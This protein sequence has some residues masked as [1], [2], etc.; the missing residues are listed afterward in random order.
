MKIPTM[1]QAKAFIEE[2]EKFNPGKWIDHSIHVAEAAQR[3]AGEH[4]DLDQETAYILGLLHDIG[5]RKGVMQMRHSVE[6][7][8]FLIE[9]GFEDAARIC[10]THS[11]PYKDIHAI[12]GKWDCTDEDITLI[13]SY[14]DATEYDGYD[15]LVQLCDVLALP[16]G[17]CLMEK[18]FVDV[19]L[20]Y[21]TSNYTILKWKAFFE[22]K[23][24]LEAQIGRSVYSVLPGI[25]EN[26]FE[27]SLNEFSDEKKL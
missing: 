19:A 15:K 5:R 27:L 8:K 22:I 16:T 20:R 25:I 13:Q 9:L 3:I 1:Q 26:T 12:C 4:P 11:F 10:L 7:Y 6:G 24:E 21:G 17:F 2:A 18:R 14:I 23:K